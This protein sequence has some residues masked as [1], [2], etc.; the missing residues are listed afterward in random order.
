[1][2]EIV[3]YWWGEIVSQQFCL[4]G[5]KLSTKPLIYNESGWESRDIYPLCPAACLAV[6][7]GNQARTGG[8]KENCTVTDL[9]KDLRSALKPTKP[10]LAS[11]PVP[12]VVTDV[13]VEINSWEINPLV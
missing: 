6:V 9:P 10:P 1:V 4:K 5:L 13:L 7:E 3:I 12:K 11:D 8:V 2:E